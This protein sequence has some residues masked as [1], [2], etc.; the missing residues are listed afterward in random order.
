MLFAVPAKNERVNSSSCV[1]K[2]E[3]IQGSARSPSVQR[4]SETLSVLCVCCALC[5]VCGAAC[6][7]RESQSCFWMAR[8]RVKRFG[9]TI[10]DKIH[11][12]FQSFYFL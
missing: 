7:V 2:K 12:R 9:T 11:C 4:L 6:K 5:C 3:E 10:R 8:E 1:S